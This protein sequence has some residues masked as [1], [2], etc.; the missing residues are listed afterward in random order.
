MAGKAG[1]RQ[2]AIIAGS[3][4]IPL[5]V[6]DQLAAHGD[7]PFIVAI[8]GEADTGLL[9]YPHEFVYPAHVGKFRDILRRIRPDAAV[10]IGGVRK[11]PDLRRVRL[12][13]TS[14]KLAARMIPKLRQ[15]DDALLR[16][17]ISVIENA[18]I[19]VV[20]VHELVPELLAP[21][22]DIAGPGAGRAEANALSAAVAGA[23]ALGALD[24]G[25]ACV[26]VGRRIVA[27][28]GVEGTDQMLQRV[29]ELRAAGRIQKHGGVLAKL[30]KPGQDLRADLPTIG[31]STIEHVA[32]AGLS[33]IAIHAGN[34]LIADYDATCRRADE[35]GVFLLGIEPDAF[36]AKGI[37]H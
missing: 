8:E 9:R 1:G 34:A 27:L 32:Q 14:I 19:P 5:Y 3:G 26:A 13:W 6:A 33:G 23:R 36:T 37:D 4:R 15:G 2:I 30:A 17:V 25:Q 16:G 18:G 20:G 31:V 21:E 29:A 10:L 11:R 12:D 35:L 28:E 24:A 7:E 22:G